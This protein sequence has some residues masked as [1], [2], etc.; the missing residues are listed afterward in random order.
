MTTRSKGRRATLAAAI[1][2]TL[3]V[4]LVAA[5][6]NPAAA[7]DPAAKALSVNLAATTGPATGVG[8]G[9]LY[10]ITEDGGQPDDQYLKPLHVNA[11]RGGGWFSGGWIKDN[12]TYGDATKA[13][14]TSIVAQAK[15]LQKTSDRPVQYQVLLSDLY[16]ANAGEP[17]NTVWPC[18]DG[19]CSNYITFLDTTITALKASGVNFAFDIWN[20]PEFSF[21]WGPGV[22]T[23][24]YF[25][26]WDTAYREIRRLAPRATIAGPSFAYTPQRMPAEW[27]TWLAHVKTAHTVPDMIS[28][29]D[30]GDVDDPV[31]VG[32]AITDDLTAA[33]LP[34]LPLS[35][36]EYQP[37]DRQ[38]A[39][40]TSWYLARFAQSRYTNAMRGNWQCCMIP[41]LTGVLGQTPSGWAPTGNWWAMR[42]YADLTGSLVTT[43]GQVGTTAISAAKD[44]LHRRA[45]A[46][47]GDSDGYTG[48]GSVTFTGLATTPWLL[49]GGK[50]HATIY[51]IPDRTPLY[52]P[53]VV[54]SQTLTVT[55]GAVTLPF[56]FQASHDAY[57]VYLSWTDPQTVTLQAPA[58][59]NAGTTYDVPVTLTNNS[60]V[61]DL[62]V[63]LALNASDTSRLKVTCARGGAATCPPVPALLPGRSATVTYRVTATS[64]LPEGGYRL[65]GT[66][67][68]LSAGGT[69]S[70]QNAA[71][72]LVPCGTDEICEAETGALA[73][74]A[75]TATDHPGY[76]GTGFVACFTAPGPGVTQNI[77]APTAGTYTLDLRYAAGPDGPAGTR[78]ATVSVNGTAQGQ[79]SLPLTGSWNTWADATTAVQL[80]A[81]S[82]AITVSYRSSDTGWFNLDHLEVTK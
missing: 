15:R 52:T 4:P 3:A 21:F 20:E 61:T 81:G 34:K 68:A 5:S 51:R 67:T 7:D 76:T 8:E 70:A 72:I 64:L 48:P 41:N 57:A 44:P 46:V 14:I 63:R 40:V 11:F 75:C 69:I 73:G 54:A 30:E 78:T 53:E 23:P 58:Q 47:I 29:H 25:Q 80:A 2:V 50:L 36:N 66:A 49:R 31:T 74:G 10:G 18:A 35:A 39:G 42:T 45:V 19:D 16:G 27:Q 62:G 38:T 6:G 32:Q 77:A 65:T 24:Q 37:A 43:S 33:G 82:N 59:L 56:T 1:I 28:N 71:D 26:M 9:F 22:N 17:S 60:G 79:V 12:Y 55:H 13:D